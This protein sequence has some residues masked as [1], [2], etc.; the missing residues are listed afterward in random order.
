MPMTGAAATD[1]LKKYLEEWQDNQTEVATIDSWYR[2]KNETPW[3]PRHF[4]EEYQDLQARSVTPWLQLVVTSVAQALYVE[5]YRRADSD[6]A[7]A[8]RIWQANGLDARQI[9]VHRASLGYGISYVTVLPGE[10]NG[11]PMPVIRGRSPLSMEAWYDDPAGDEWPVYAIR[12]ELLSETPRVTRL[13]L[14]DAEAVY[15]FEVK[16]ERQ[17]QAVEFVTVDEHGAGVCPVIRFCQNLDLDGRSFGEVEPF[18]PLAARID[19]DTFD[20]LVVQ[21]FGA[22]IVRT[23]SGMDLD[24]D[25]PTL[26]EAENLAAAEAA[27][28]KLRVSDFLVSNDP[29]TKFG[30]L[31]ASPLDGYIKSRDADIRD[32]AAVSQTPPHHLLGVVANLS[33]EAL[34]AAESSLSRKV[35]E[36]KHAFGES[37]EQVLRLAAFISGDSE[38][39]KDFEAEV[40]WR[41]MES[42]SLAQTADALGKL[43]TMLGVPV[44]MLWE[45][46]PGWTQ[47]DVTRAKEL[48]ENADPF[49][50]LMNDLNGAAQSDGEASDLKARFDALGVAIRAGVD[51]ADAARRLG[52]EGIGFT[53]AIPTS[54]RVPQSDAGSLEDA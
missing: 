7:A 16:G 4:T 51:P 29:E 26:T 22:W 6:N 33:A 43:A 13:W 18:I 28:K 47:Q 39:A 17:A 30:S 21:R 20:R 14:Y 9:S 31:P 19:Q 15:T 49:A 46:V 42:R 10:V 3:M 48:A 27:A 23:I 5:G 50:G 37:W 52:L 25:D 12:G 36:R 34:A 24:T 11:G 32:L 8:W 1:V 45:K 35:E 44:E 53:G 41:D 2:G 54:L 40:R 38:G